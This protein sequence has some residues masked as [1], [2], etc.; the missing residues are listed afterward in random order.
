LSVLNIDPNLSLEKVNNFEAK[1]I[2]VSTGKIK[3]EDKDTSTN[4][5]Y[6]NFWYLSDDKEEKNPLIIEFSFDYNA[7]D[8]RNK[9][10]GSFDE[11]TLE[12]FSISLI[13]KINDF[14]LGL[15]KQENFIDL[16]ESKTKTEFVY[17]WKHNR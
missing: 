5:L 4:D 13:R 15:F 12:E 3:F 14:Y 9:S 7:K 8:K 1:E 2:S 17:E 6:L 16:K 10:K 11:K